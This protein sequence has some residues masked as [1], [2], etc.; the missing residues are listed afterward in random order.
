MHIVDTDSRLPARQ[1]NHSHRTEPKKRKKEKT[2]N[3]VSIDLFSS[4]S[5]SY[6]TCVLARR[7]MFYE[8]VVVSHHQR[9]VAIRTCITQ[10]TMKL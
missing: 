10:R 6:R 3:K 8:A 2:K 9:G 5:A 1:N 4:T 7:L